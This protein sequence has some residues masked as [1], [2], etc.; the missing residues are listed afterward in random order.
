MK[1]ISFI[2]ARQDDIIEKT[3]RHCGQWRDPPPRATPKLSSPSRPQGIVPQ[4][5]PGFTLEPDGES[6]EHSRRQ[7]L[8]QPELPWEP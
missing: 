8:D 1:I 4:R 5:D 2:E 6:L 7:Q 3:L